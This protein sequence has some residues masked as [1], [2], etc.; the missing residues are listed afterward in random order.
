MPRILVVEDNAINRELLCD[1]LNA[2]GYAVL[3]AEDLGGA[4]RLLEGEPSDAVLLDVQLGSEDGLSLAAWM[5]RQPELSGIPVIAVT[6]HAMMTEQQR[7]L[8]S[9]CN[10]C[11]SKPIDFKLLDQELHK[12]LALVQKSPSRA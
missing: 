7:F 9:G 12:W 3:S 5:R 6:A 11:I 2:Q 10:A 1:W 8:Q 4:Q